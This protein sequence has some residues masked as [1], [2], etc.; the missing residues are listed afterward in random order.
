MFSGK[1]TYLIN[2]YNKSNNKKKILVI[3]YSDDIRYNKSNV[4]SHDNLMIPSLSTKKLLLID[5]IQLKQYDIILI[6]EGQ[7]FTNLDKWIRTINFKGQIYISALNGDSKKQSFGDISK[8][9]SFT[10]DIIFLHGK[11][12]YCNQKSCYSQKL[13]DDLNQIDIGGN[14]KYVPVCEKCYKTV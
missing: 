1:T 8:L 10:N 12:H 7:F 14:D 11:C 2:K 4:I 3:K 6:D 5:N 9:I 13:T